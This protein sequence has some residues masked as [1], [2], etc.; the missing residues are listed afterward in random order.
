M[1][2]DDYSGWGFLLAIVA[3][4]A[5]SVNIT[6]HWWYFVIYPVIGFAWSIWRYKKYVAYKLS[7]VDAGNTYGDLERIKRGLSIAQQG[8][9]VVYWILLWPTNMLVNVFADV[10]DFTLDLVKVRLASIYNRILDGET[11]KRTFDDTP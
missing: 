10:W 2:G 7:L 5:I 3:L 6:M 8:E 9:R 11:N 4:V 1:R